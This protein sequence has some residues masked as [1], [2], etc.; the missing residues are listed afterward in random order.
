LINNDGTDAVAGT[1]N[2]VAEGDTVTASGGQNFTISYAGGDGNDVVLVAQTPPS[3]SPPVNT[4][5][6][7]G[8]TATPVRLFAV[9]G[10]NGVVSV[11]NSDGSLRAQGDL[12]GGQGR[13]VRVAT[14]DLNGDGVDDIVISIGSGSLA[15]LVMGIDGATLT[16]LGS[17]FA[18]PSLPGSG[19][20]AAIGDVTGD[21]YADLI[22]ATA[23][24]GAFVQ[25]YDI[26]HG[27]MMVANFNAIPG[28]T[29][30][31]NVAVGNLDATGPAEI[32]VGAAQGAPIVAEYNTAGQLLDAFLAY[33]MGYTGGVNVAA[34]DVLGT[35]G[36]A[37]ILV[38]PAS[39]GTGGLVELF[40][41]GN[42]TPI[43]AAN[44]PLSPSDT[45]VRVS[46]QDVDGNGNAD[47]AL[48]SGPS[49]SRVLAFDF[50]T[51]TLLRDFIAF[52]SYPGGVYVG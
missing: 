23:S 8:S 37:E 35:D 42:H 30:G 6:G 4:T 21:G 40:T 48:G 45:G 17:F 11:Y 1:F 36:N 33:P 22:L 10:G 16:S 43:A 13:D 50:R 15:G 46:I 18:F 7:G 51:Q 14:G 49:S 29:G 52:P 27:G 31:V 9:A 41:A 25:A 12:F 19:V 39:G 26:I 24:G 32:I 28:F 38:G 47:L 44:L 3:T 34:G 20:S 2:G 5:P